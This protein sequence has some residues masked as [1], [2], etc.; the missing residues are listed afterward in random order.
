MSRAYV[1]N[2]LWIITP[3]PASS[4]GKTLELSDFLRSNNI[5]VAAISETHLQPGEKIWV[6]DYVPV[7]LER[8]RCRKG[9][10][11]VLVHHLAHFRVLPSLQTKIIEA[12]GVEID[13]STGPVAVVAV[14]C[15]SQ[16]RESDSSVTDFKNDLAKL[17][18]R[19]PRFVVAGDL[20]ARHS[21]WGNHR[22]NKNGVVLAEDLQAGHYVVL[23]PDS[24]TFF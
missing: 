21:L 1:S 12:V 4:F 17:T 20:N 7:T 2:H 22:N 3:Q 18:R 10:V 24:P 11:A 13:T 19:F 15:P 14:Y 23:H 5:E 9:G 8:T 16:C 6:P